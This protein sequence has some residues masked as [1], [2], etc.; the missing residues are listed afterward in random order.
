[1]GGTWKRYAEEDSATSHGQL[2]VRIAAKFNI[3]IM[4]PGAEIQLPSRIQLGLAWE[5]I[6]PTKPV[7]LNASIVGLSANGTLVDLVWFKKLRG[8]DGAVV[9]SG[10]NTSGEGDGDD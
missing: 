6:H 7:D 4:I 1:M 10:D 3:P 2:H 9:H 5:F 8:F